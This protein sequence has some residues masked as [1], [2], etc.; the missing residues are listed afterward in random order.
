ME[1]HEGIGEPGPTGPAGRGSD[2]QYRLAREATRSRRLPRGGVQWED[3]ALGAIISP[4]SRRNWPA[5]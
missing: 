1:E 3:Q 4:T 2:G 5:L